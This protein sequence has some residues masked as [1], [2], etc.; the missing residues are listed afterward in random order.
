[1]PTSLRALWRIHEA[2][3][4]LCVQSIPILY[5]THTRTHT[6][7]STYTHTHTCSLTLAQVNQYLDDLALSNVKKDRP[8]VKKALQLLLR[9]T[10]A[11]EQKWLIRVILKVYGVCII[12]VEPL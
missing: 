6:H 5:D 1:M 12:I 11:I 7:G 4:S 9:N 3:L 8:G 10:S 2:L